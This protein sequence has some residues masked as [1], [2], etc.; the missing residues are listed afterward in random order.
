VSATP[1]ETWLSAPGTRQNGSGISLDR[2]GSGTFSA[3]PLAWLTPGRLSPLVRLTA[4]AVVSFR[5]PRLVT[6]HSAV[7]QTIY[8]ISHRKVRIYAAPHATLIVTLSVRSILIHSWVRRFSHGA[9]RR[10]E[11]HKQSLAVLSTEIGRPFPRDW[12]QPPP[13]R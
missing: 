11:S 6:R 8:H 9:V 3:A 5:F 4:P 10:H 2:F 13:L 12:L 7:S 1:P